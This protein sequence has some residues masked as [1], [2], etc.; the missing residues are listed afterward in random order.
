MMIYA[1]E[2]IFE[3]GSHHF[4]F[5]ESEDERDYHFTAYRGSDF[6]RR[7]NFKEVDYE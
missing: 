3:D 7:R 1:L 6:I 5:Y 4:A 2:Y